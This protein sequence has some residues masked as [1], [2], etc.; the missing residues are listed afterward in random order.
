MALSHLFRAAAEF[1][2]EVQQEDYLG[3]GFVSA[4]YQ[5]PQLG[6]PFSVGGQIESSVVAGIDEIRGPNAGF[7]GDEGITSGTI[8]HHHHAIRRKIEQFTAVARPNGKVT[9][10]RDLP[11][12]PRSWKRAHEDFP[13]SG[14]IGHVGDPAPI[15]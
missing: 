9:A 7:L 3:R 1:I 10:V 4:A 14:F 5:R 11:A 12:A 2:E 15:W 8:I 13:A 6:E